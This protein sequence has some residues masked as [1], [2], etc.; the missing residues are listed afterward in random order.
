MYCSVSEII[1]KI[2]DDLVNE[3]D[4]T[5]KFRAKPK[6]KPPRRNPSVQNES[7]RTD[8]MKNYM[9]EYREDGNDY[10]KKPEL[11]KELRKKQ[12]QRVE[13]KVAFGNV[14]IGVNHPV[15]E[16]CIVENPGTLHLNNSGSK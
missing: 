14:G 3:G 1:R 9:K 12:R 11:I 10:Q 8:Y 4:V 7:N 2:A 13:E 6:K 5:K 15:Y 16:F